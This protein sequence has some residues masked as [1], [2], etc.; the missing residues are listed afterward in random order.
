MHTRKGA[1]A[2]RRSA[3]Q[4]RQANRRVCGEME[5]LLRAYDEA[6]KALVIIQ[7]HHIAAAAERD[8]KSGLLEVEIQSARNHTDYAK[9]AYL[10]HI[11]Q[12]GC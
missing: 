1:V 12:H 8:E 7:N 11:L 3:T 2:T 5:R 4:R 6:L 9:L 10:T